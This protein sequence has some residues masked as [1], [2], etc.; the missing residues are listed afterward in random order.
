MTIKLVWTGQSFYKELEATSKNLWRMGLGLHGTK[1]MKT[2]NR[3]SILMTANSVLLNQIFRK[4]QKILKIHPLNMPH[5]NQRN[6]KMLMKNWVNRDS[7]GRKWNKKHKEKIEKK[8][9]GSNKERRNAK[10][11]WKK[12]DDLWK[13]NLLII[14]NLIIFNFIISRYF[15]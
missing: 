15:S 13:I 8:S 4:N 10:T 6:L 3:E 9:E 2:M 5:K 12:R 14:I 1:L 11:W 7:L